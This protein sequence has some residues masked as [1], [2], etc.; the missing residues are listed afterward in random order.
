MARRFVPITDTWGTPTGCRDTVTG[1]ILPANSP[2]CD[3][4]YGSMVTPS[5][6]VSTENIFP[7]GKR[8]T[9]KGLGAGPPRWVTAA[10]FGVAGLLITGAIVRKNRKGKKGKDQMVTLGAP[11]AAGLVSAFLGWGIHNLI[12]TPEP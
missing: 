4:K 3:P 8:S 10:G 11:V 5:G 12:F 6:I 2:L 9:L 1:N 7:I